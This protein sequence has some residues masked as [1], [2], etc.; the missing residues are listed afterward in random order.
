MAPPESDDGDPTSTAVPVVAVTTTAL[1]VGLVAAVRRRR[2]RRNHLFPKSVPLPTG[3]EAL[4]RDL[5]V[6]ADEAS[7]DR[8]A[9]VLDRLAHGIA[10]SGED[11]RPLIV[12]HGHDH[13]E[14]LLDRPAVRPVDGWNAAGDGSVLILDPDTTA[15]G[16]NHRW[17]SPAPLLRAV[18]LVGPPPDAVG[19]IAERHQDVG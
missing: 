13:T 18:L 8:L 6:A 15:S 4:H 10:G 12:Q 19:D 2:R 5:F 16:N 14:V 11:C 7:V 17:T 1:A 3:H 9:V